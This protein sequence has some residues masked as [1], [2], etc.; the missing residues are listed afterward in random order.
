MTDEADSSVGLAELQVAHD[1]H[2]CQIDYKSHHAWQVMARTQ[3]GFTKAYKQ[4]LST[5][6]DLDL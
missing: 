1:D 2:L 5:D 3:T 4:S 6:C